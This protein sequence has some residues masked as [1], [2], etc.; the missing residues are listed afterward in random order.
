MESFYLSL[1]VVAP[2][3]VIMALGYL[4]KQL[5][6]VN[7]TTVTQMNSVNF[8]TFLPTSIFL[9]IY[10]AN[11]AESLNIRLMLLC[12]VGVLVIFFALMAVVPKLEPENPRRSS[13]IQGIYRSNF[14]IFGLTIT[15]AIYGPENIGV[16]AALVIII[17]P[18]YNALA[19]F[20]FEY[21]RGGDVK[22]GPLMKKIATNP[23]IVGS[24]LGLFFKVTGLHLPALGLSILEDLA[25]VATPLAMVI[26]GMSFTFG[27]MRKYAS[28]LWKVT[29]LR[30]LLIPGV[31]LLIAIL[32]GFRGVELVTVM[33]IFGTPAAIASFA[34]AKSMGGDADL[35]GQIVVVTSVASVATIFG[36]VYL[37]SSIG[38]I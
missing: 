25:G 11:V 18:L 26:L 36:W 10:K 31:M 12:A 30:L 28:Y 6:M 9:S 3:F 1:K 2:I 35:A 37:L 16:N 38:F 32:M 17:T 29:F 5:K 22:A 14:V 34:M 27:N 8:R 21:F 15:T 33:T 19:S 20:L 4:L 24:L 13:L 23:F 7:D